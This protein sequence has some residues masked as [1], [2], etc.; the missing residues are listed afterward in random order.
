MEDFD[1]GKAVGELEAIAKKVEDPQT[2]IDDI[3][4]Y[5]RRSAEL[6]D[7]CRKYLRS[8]REKAGEIR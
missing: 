6:I 8:A 7:R 4:I 2:G 3:D 5:I 1:Y